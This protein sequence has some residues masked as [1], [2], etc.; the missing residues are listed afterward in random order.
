MVRA[1]ERGQRAAGPGQLQ[2]AQ[3]DFLVAA[4]GIGH[5]GAVARERRRIEHDQVKLRYQLFVRLR[6]R[7]GLEPVENVRRFGGAFLLETIGLGVTQ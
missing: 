7:V 1:A 3:M 6:L 5:G 4:E 2:G